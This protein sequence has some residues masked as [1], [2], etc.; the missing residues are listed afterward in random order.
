[1]DRLEQTWAR[2]SMDLDRASDDS[3]RIGVEIGVL[4]AFVPL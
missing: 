3:R 2:R 4:C 1:M